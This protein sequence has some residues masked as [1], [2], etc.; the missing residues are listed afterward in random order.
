MITIYCDE[1]GFTGNNLL[2]DDQPYFVY[3]SVS[4]DEQEARQIVQGAIKNHK[5]ELS[6]MKGS[7]LIRY[8]KGQQA[9]LSILNRCN[10]HA[11][12]LI[13]EKKY[14]LAAKFYE[15]MF[16]PILANNSLLFYN[17]GFHRFIAS[18]LYFHFLGKDETTIQVLRDFED[19][20]K[21]KDFPRIAN[22]LKSF[23][24]SRKA[25][26]FMR[27]I[28]S[29][30]LKNKDNIEEEWEF[31]KQYKD[32]GKWILDLTSTS[33]QSLLTEWGKS[34][35]KLQVMCDASKPLLQQLDFFNTFVGQRDLITYN[36]EGGNTTI[37]Y[38]LTEEIKM[39]DSRNHFSIQIADIFAS[40]LSYALKNRGTEFSEK[41][42]ALCRNAISEKSP[43]PD[44]QY[45]DMKAKPCFINSQ[46]LEHLTS[47]VNRKQ[48]ILTDIH[49]K[50]AELNMLFPQWLAYIRTQEP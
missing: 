25:P 17:I 48:D 41:C 23:R 33:L 47:K 28:A 21:E 4:I 24:T 16:E 38:N 10:Q 45:L 42:I 39:V 35:K 44:V 1:S 6:E 40:S 20:L 32:I 9:V 19:A 43:A 29:F 11:S 46:V 8:Y 27:R 7:K 49:I 5:I 30:T 50:I 12:V 18:G 36:I 15:Y 14:A 37:T 2:S 31:L 26:P 34:G 3:S 22:T 13:I